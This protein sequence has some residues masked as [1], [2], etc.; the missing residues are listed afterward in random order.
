LKIDAT[1]EVLFRPMS[2]DLNLDNEEFL[3]EACINQDPKAQKYLFDKYASRM[4]G[5]CSRYCRNLDD[6]RDAMQDGY[7]K[8][9][10]IISKFNRQS[11]LETWMT[12]VMMNTA[13]DHYKKESKFV[14]FESGED[15]LKYKKDTE[16]DYILLAEEIEDISQEQMLKVISELPDGY[17]VVFNMYAIE[18]LSHRDISNHL[19]ISEGTSK[20]QLAR[21]K[22][23]LRDKF[24]EKGLIG[25]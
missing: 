22:K 13:I 21:A 10:S 18:G 3:I 16:E 6:A 9:F 12:R 7:V 15:V 25:R 8:I 4:L 1:K 19:G 23:Y 17:R 11:K 2:K 5:V 20:S 24:L 14:L